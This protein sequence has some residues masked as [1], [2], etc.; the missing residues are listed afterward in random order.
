[1]MKNF[2]PIA[3]LAAT[4]LTA[5]SCSTTRVL[6]DDQYRLEKNRIEIVNDKEFNPNALNPYLKQKHKG[7]S[8]FR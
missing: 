4:L 1:M 2:R 3:I 5:I 8:P 7:W 6:Q